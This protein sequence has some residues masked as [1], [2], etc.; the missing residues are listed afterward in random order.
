LSVVWVN[1]TLVKGF[2]SVTSVP[3]ITA[4]VASVTTP[5][6]EELS[7][8]RRKVANDRNMNDR[9]SLAN[10]FFMDFLQKLWGGWMPVREAS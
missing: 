1:V 6:I 8:A 9:E 10:R 5:V 2:E 3:G 4:P 7:C